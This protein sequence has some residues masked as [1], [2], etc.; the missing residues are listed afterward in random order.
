M[1]RILSIFVFAV[2]AFNMLGQTDKPDTTI[3]RETLNDYFSIYKVEGYR[4]KHTKDLTNSDIVIDDSLRRITIHASESFCNQPLTPKKVLEI[5]RVISCCLFPPYNYYNVRIINNDSITLENLIPNYERTDSTADLSRVW[6]D[7]E[8]KG[9]AWMKNISRPYEI[10]GGLEGRHIMIWPSH[11]RYYKEGKWEWQRPYLFCTT[12]D[13]FTQSIV[14]P[15]LFPM[16]ENAGAIV[17]DPRERDIQTSMVVVDNDVEDSD[18][19][20]YKEDNESGLAWTYTDIKGFK[21]KGSPIT[22]EDIP[23]SSG[24]ARKIRVTSKR[25]D[26]AKA[27][28]TP[29]IP[30]DGRYAVY[31]SYQT[32]PTSIDDAHYTVYHKGGRTEFIVNQQMGGGTWLYLGTFE[33]EN[34][35]NNHSRVELSNYSTS[36]GEVTADAV[37]FGGGMSLVSRGS[38]GVSGLPRFI[39]AARYNTQYSGLSYDLFT[40]G[41][42]S[43]DYNADIACR[44]NFLNFL[45][46]GSV[47]MPQREGLK[48]PFELSVAVH[49]DAGYRADNGIFGTLTIGTTTGDGGARYFSSGVSRYASD[50][51]A[52]MMLKTI[53]E[54]MSAHLGLTWTRREMWDRNYGETRIPDVPSTILEFMSHQNYGDLKYA[55]DPYVKFLLAR[56]FYKGILKFINFQHGINDYTLQPLPVK[57]FSALL[58]DDGK[59]AILSWEPTI[60]EVDSTARPTSYIIYTK[61]GDG[62]FDNGIKVEETTAKIA[63]K[64]GEQFS[65]KVAACNAGGVSFPSEVL[66]VYSS[67]RS[68]RKILI[69][70]GF[71]RIS[72]P[73]H[74]ETADS[75]GFL[76]NADMGVPYIYN[77]SY[78]GPQIN[79]NASAGGSEGPNALGYSDNSMQGKVFAGNTFDY[80]YV[81]GKAI[82]ESG[83]ASFESC[84]RGSLENGEVELKNY[85]VL[86]FIAGL[87]KDVSYNLKDYSIFTPSIRQQIETYTQ[88]GGNIFISGSYIASNLTKTEDRDFARDVLH[89]THADTLLADFSEDIN[90]LGKVIPIYRTPND[91]HYAAVDPDV[92]TPSD[93]ATFSAFAYSEGHSA[94]IAYNGKDYKVIATGFPFECIIDEK[95]RATAMHAILKFLLGK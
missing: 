4:Y 45:G 69:V 8:H 75:I 10:T 53:T 81:H 43:N 59:H 91:I 64:K 46:G 77:A 13:L 79:F 60:D 50:D 21:P 30:R 83:L 88:G 17:C 76:L 37:R 55:H 41:N 90:G 19:G 65:F 3:I 6:G 78:C 72:G 93:D 80:P 73:A 11:G 15:Y 63:I 1:K 5:E 49:S 35:K 67:N 61:R 52:N 40:R 16:L 14:L 12:E 2:C 51:F 47:Y 23:F 57:N 31:V 71:N 34:G 58:S 94:G 82:A 92:V 9:N 84:S 70:N 66:S 68:S 24:T 36:I 20:T 85:A 87:Q 44:P 38:A 54:D 26:A 25:E 29:R 22:D 42:V 7:I 48:V 62:S 27:V 86:D 32:L 18:E 74:I 28:W 33:F 39:E 95:M 89:Y 56:C